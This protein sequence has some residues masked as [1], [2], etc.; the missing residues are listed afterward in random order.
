MRYPLRHAV[1]EFLD[2]YSGVYADSTL[3]EYRRRYARLCRIME[4][5]RSQGKVSTLDPS[6][7]VPEDVIALAVYLRKVRGVRPASLQ[8]DVGALQTLCLFCGNDAVRF[9]RARCPQAFPK[10]RKGRLPVVERQVFESFVR[11][12]DLAPPER[13]RAYAVVAF[14]FGTGLRPCEIRAVCVGDVSVPDRTVAVRRPKGSET[15]GI[16]R[17][18]PI[19]PECLGVISRWILS[20]RGAPEDSPLFPNR[21]GLPLSENGLRKDRVS[22]CAETG[23][24]FDFRICRRTYGQYLLDEGYPLEYVS[25]LLGHTNETTTARFYGRV[26]PERVVKNV[27]QGWFSKEGDNGFIE[28]GD[29]ESWTVKSGAREGI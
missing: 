27:I 21:E 18:V 29:G 22:V 17:T 28:D 19:R 11:R 10:E 20:L 24:S 26:R 9:A 13:L 25:S 6:R 2:V 1:N 12:A 16:P 14:A 4:D 3:K 8:H 7:M 15:Y 5:L 23:L